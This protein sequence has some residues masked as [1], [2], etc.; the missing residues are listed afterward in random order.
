RSPVDRGRK[1]SKHHAEVDGQGVPLGATT[2][3]ANTPDVAALPSVIDAV[4]PVRRRRRPPRR[5]P[6]KLYG[7]PA[8]DSYP[9]RAEVRRRGTGSRGRTA[10]RL[11]GLAA[12][13]TAPR[14]V[15]LVRRRSPA[16]PPV[17]AVRVRRTRRHPAVPRQR[18]TP[19]MS[20]PARKALG[21]SRTGGR[22][23]PGR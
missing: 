3:A 15:A 11:P 22:P 2:T 13:C 9:R 8:Y 10:N 1:G 18:H 4:P 12:P 16:T 6:K 7:G 5:R 14:V 19:P 23:G 17:V 21:Q 20:S